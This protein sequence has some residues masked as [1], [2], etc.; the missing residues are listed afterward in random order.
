MTV[1]VEVDDREEALKNAE[2]LR[3]RTIADPAEF[4]DKRPSAHGKGAVKFAYFAD[5]KGHVIGLRR[6]IVRQ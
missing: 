4:P 2:R 1:F 5:P 3:G 6:G